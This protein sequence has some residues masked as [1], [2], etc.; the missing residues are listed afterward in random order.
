MLDIASLAEIGQKQAEIDFRF[1]K[2]EQSIAT[3][4]GRSSPLGI[5]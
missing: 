3:K 2:I 5:I 4:S 1:V